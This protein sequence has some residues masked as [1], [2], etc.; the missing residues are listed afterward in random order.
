MVSSLAEWC[1]TGSVIF[2]VALVVLELNVETKLGSCV[3]ESR[4]NGNFTNERTNI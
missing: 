4:S 1:R 3:S 2:I